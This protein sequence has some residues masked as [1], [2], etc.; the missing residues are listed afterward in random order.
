[1][2]KQQADYCSNLNASLYEHSS[3]PIQNLPQFSQ[4]LSNRV[5]SSLYLNDTYE[6]E[7]LDIIK[8]FENGKASDI[9]TILIKRSAKIITP[10]LT[11]LYNF[12]MSVGDFPSTFKTGK[13]TP[14]F[15]KGD[16][17]LLE[18]YRPVSI[19]PIFGKI[20]EKIIHKRLYSFLTAKHILNIKQ[21][22]FRKGR[23]TVHAACCELT[24]CATP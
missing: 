3:L 24:G 19:L 14:I 21:F 22:G 11:K 10:V 9:P 17:E 20:F 13:I 18:N 2:H 8:E 12:C 15:K 23:S 4:Y 7:I 16:A 5:E 6:L 1:M